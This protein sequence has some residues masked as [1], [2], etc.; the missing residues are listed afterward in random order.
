LIWP[1][2]ATSRPA[3]LGGAAVDEQLDA[4]DEVSSRLRAFIDW[5]AE[6]FARQ[7]AE[8][9]ADWNPVEVPGK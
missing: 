8:G 1:P 3:Y 4:V 9:A 5:V 2:A 7:L 6:A